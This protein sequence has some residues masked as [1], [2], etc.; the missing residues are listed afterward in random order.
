MVLTVIFGENARNAVANSTYGCTVSVPKCSTA[1]QFHFS[2][3]LRFQNLAGRSTIFTWNVTAWVLLLY[4]GP[5]HCSC[6]RT[7]RVGTLMATFIMKDE[8]RCDVD[9]AAAARIL[10]SL[11]CVKMLGENIAWR[12]C[13]AVYCSLFTNDIRHKA[14]SL[15]TWAPM[16]WIV[17]TNRFSY[18]FLFPASVL[19]SN[20]SMVTE[21]MSTVASS[22]IGTK[23]KRMALSCLT[24]LVFF[25][26]LWKNWM[27]VRKIHFQKLSIW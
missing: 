5:R 3:F 11:G 25:D 12:I 2:A 22:Q 20:S 21:T 9:V 17:R 6:H 4:A 7:R 27:F 13:L 23:R 15:H 18:V 14:R 26:R 8:A 16:V 19:L 10:R 1:V 24:S